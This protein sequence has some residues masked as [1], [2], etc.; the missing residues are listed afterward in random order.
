[1]NTY[2]IILFVIVVIFLVVIN[3]SYNSKSNRE[4]YGPVKQFKRPPKN[5]CY[6]NCNQ[7]YTGCMARYQYVDSGD[8]RGR[9]DR[10]I[11]ACNYSDFHKQ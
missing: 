6:E 4:N 8:C 10:C 1:M 9:F 3:K 5:N 2:K 7:Y 11:A